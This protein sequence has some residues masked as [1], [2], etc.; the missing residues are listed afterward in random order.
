MP[1]SGDG[2]WSSSTC[3]VFSVSE[4]IHPGTKE[5]TASRAVGAGGMDAGLG[6]LEQA[7][8]GDRQSQAAADTGSAAS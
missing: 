8:T 6:G 4:M 3:K 1:G 5:D 2:T 7:E